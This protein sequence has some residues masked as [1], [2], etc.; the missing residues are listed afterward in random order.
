MEEEILKI[1]RQHLAETI[2]KLEKEKENLENSLINVRGNSSDEYITAYLSAI[3]QKKI[4]DIL[5]SIDRP[6]FA[7]MDV[8]ENN[9]KEELYIGKLSV[10]DSK[11]QEPIVVDWRAPISNLY[12]ENDF[13]K[14]NYK[15]NEVEINL[16]VILKRQ[17]FINNRI[18]YIKR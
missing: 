13:G 18:F 12:Y 14:S 10:L 11:T 4:S 7:R 15:V 9:K 1:E 17:F 16:E 6:Y 2:K 5:L 8:L 3:N